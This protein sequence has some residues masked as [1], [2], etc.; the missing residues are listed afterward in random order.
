MYV[1]YRTYAIEYKLFNISSV[2]PKR[3][4][5]NLKQSNLYTYLGIN[6]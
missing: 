2:K 1:M 5:F 3:R 4:L 6:Y